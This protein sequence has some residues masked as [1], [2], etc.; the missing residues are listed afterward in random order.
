MGQKKK[1]RNMVSAEDRRSKQNSTGRGGG[2]KTR[3]DV[4]STQANK[5]MSG[6]QVNSPR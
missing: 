5:A 1:G 4:P 2:K 6:K 3:N